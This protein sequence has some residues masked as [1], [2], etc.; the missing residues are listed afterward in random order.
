[1]NRATALTAALAMGTA[2]AAATIVPALAATRSAAPAKAAAAR[3]APAKHGIAKITAQA[4]K[5]AADPVTKIGSEVDGGKFV[6]VV[7]CQGV[8][9]PPP[10]KLGAPGAPLTASGI[11]PSAGLLSMLQKPNP[12]KTVY[13]CTV[14]VKVKVPPKPKVCMLP[15]SERTNGKCTRRVTLNTGFGGMAPQVRMHNPA[16]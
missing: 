7:Q 16:G 9:V 15:V 5:V 8:T 11:G 2:V 4:L 14:I 10:I 13:T 6:T 3:A 1:M 12:Y